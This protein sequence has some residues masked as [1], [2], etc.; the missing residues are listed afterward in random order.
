MVPLP[1][2]NSLHPVSHLTQ[3][4]IYHVCSLLSVLLPIVIAN[5]LLCSRDLWWCCPIFLFFYFFN[6][7][8]LI[9]S[10]RHHSMTQANA[11]NE[12][13]RVKLVFEFLQVI[14]A[15]PSSAMW[16]S[17]GGECNFQGF[18]NYLLIVTDLFLFGQQINNDN[19]QRYD[20]YSTG[21]KFGNT[22][23]INVFINHQCVG[24]LQ[25]R[26]IGTYS[27]SEQNIHR[28]CIM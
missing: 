28:V 9:F 15:K 23:S 26:L 22:F 2:F 6:S 8:K 4:T 21:Q 20:M 14:C 12:K 5:L 3:N 17:A 18:K 7:A 25:S 16:L 11:E 27:L 10:Y 1:L 24:Y 13:I 19:N